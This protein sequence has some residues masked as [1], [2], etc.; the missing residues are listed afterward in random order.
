MGDHR[1]SNAAWKH[2]EKNSF[3]APIPEAWS[4]FE[5]D[6]VAKFAA[7]KAEAR[8]LLKS[9]KRAEAVKVMNSTAESIW[10]EAAKLLNI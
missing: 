3:S 9:G 10:N 6:A 8:K 7:A 1:W 2:F 5:T 4:K